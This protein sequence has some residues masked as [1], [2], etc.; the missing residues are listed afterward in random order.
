MMSLGESALKRLAEAF[1]LVSAAIPD[2]AESRSYTTHLLQSTA[3]GLDLHS[4]FM[5]LLG[6]SE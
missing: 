2:F 6:L 1:C 4:S 3:G 5:L